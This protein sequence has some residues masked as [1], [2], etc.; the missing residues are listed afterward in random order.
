MIA[1]AIPLLF[2]AVFVGLLGCRDTLVDEPLPDTQAPPVDTTMTNELYLKG[3]LTLRVDET[4]N[5]R[6]EPL[7]GAERYQ[8]FLSGGLGTVI[9]T[10]RDANFQFYDITGVD[11]GPVTLT[12]QAYDAN[13]DVIGIGTK[14]ITVVE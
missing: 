3:P 9:G 5:F 13:D 12:V 1:R 10:P 4:R 7:M 6:A 8:W 2:L 14:S 11:P